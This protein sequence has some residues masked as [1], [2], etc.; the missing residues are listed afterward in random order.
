M[1]AVL[2]RLHSPDVADLTSWTPDGDSWQLLVQAILGPD[3]GPGEE[4]FD[5]VVC[6]PQVV[7]NWATAD[8]RWWGQYT[9]V[10]TRWDY[11]ALEAAIRDLL[12][13]CDGPDWSTVAGRL[14]HFMHWEFTD[15]RGR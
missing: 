15:Y 13:R 11:T 12:A 14:A 4:S 6:S 1:K 9:L 5:V 2:R 3:D 7:A 8:G 10:V